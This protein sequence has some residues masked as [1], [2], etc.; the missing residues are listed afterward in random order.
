MTRAQR[1]PV[2]PRTIRP[3]A[4]A[5]AAVAVVIGLVTAG[6]QDDDD[7]AK[8]ITLPSAPTFSMPS[9]SIPEFTPPSLPI[10]SPRPV[11]ATDDET[12][13]TSTR[14]PTR[15]PSPTAK[16]SDFDSGACLA[17]KIEET[18]REQDELT[19]VSCSDPTATFKIIKTYPYSLGGRPCDNVSGVDYSYD[20]YMTRNGVPTGV[21]TTYCLK[22]L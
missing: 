11:T 18:G 4:V 9:I 16:K 7:N 15:S 14:T 1:T 19:E 21:G 20:E 22:Q 6:C 13:D 2:R 10:T 12:D 8:P 5:V 3:H 17:G